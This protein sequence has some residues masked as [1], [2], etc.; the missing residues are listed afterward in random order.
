M[1][2]VSYWLI[3][4]SIGIDLSLLAYFAIVPIVVVVTNLPISLGGI[5]LRE[6]AAVALLMQFGVD[7]SLATA[8]AMGYLGVLLV[9]SLPGGLVLLTG[10]PSSQESAQGETGRTVEANV[11]RNTE[12]PE[13]SLL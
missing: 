8:N 9:T 2:V 3:G 1:T 12:Q 5:G 13:S 11:T 7:Q 6:G 10:A 4:L